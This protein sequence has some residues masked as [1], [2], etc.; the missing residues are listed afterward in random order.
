MTLIGLILVLIVLGFA[1]WAVQ[2][3]PMINTWFKSI[4]IGIIII[5]TLI[6]MLNFFGF[7][8]GINTNLR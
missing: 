4:I 8:T 5:F 7:A 2:T 1:C 3:A 6:L